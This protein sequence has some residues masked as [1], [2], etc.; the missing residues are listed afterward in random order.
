MTRPIVTLTPPALVAATAE[1]G[2]KVP[3]SYYAKSSGSQK[4]GKGTPAKSSKQTGGGGGSFD[5]A[6]H[7]RHAAGSGDKSGEFA[8][9][10]GGGKDDAGKKAQQNKSAQ[11]NFLKLAGMNPADSKK[12]LAGLS[13]K[14]LTE[15]TEIAYSAKTSDK[16]VVT[17]RNQI[18]A[19]MTKRGLSVQDHG[20]RGGGLPK[21][22]KPGAKKAPAKKAVKASAGPLVHLGGDTT[23]VVVAA[24]CEPAATNSLVR[25]GA[26]Q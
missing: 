10:G 25:I 4:G 7:P 24:A 23:P 1:D 26:A 11:A 12:F 6:K 14:D 21:G 20:A 19:E 5:E 13:E 2:S 16:K 18:S 15:L 17:Q 3:D 9:A 8:P 22:S